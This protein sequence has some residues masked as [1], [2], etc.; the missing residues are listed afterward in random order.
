MFNLDLE[1]KKFQISSGPL[2]TV[3][4][5]FKCG[6]RAAISVFT[7]GYTSQKTDQLFWAQR[8]AKKGIDTILF[9]LPGH[10]LGE[11]SPVENFEDFTKYCPQLFSEALNL[12]S[13]QAHEKVILG[14]HSLGALLSLK[15]LEL[16][17]LSPFKKLTIAVGM[18]LELSDSP[19][20][21]EKDFFKETL[22]FRKNLVSPALAP[23][24]FFPWM[25][26]MKKNLYATNE[27]IHLIAGEDDIIV[28][29][30]GVE[31]LAKI[32]EEKNNIVTFEKPR[33]LPHFEPMLAAPYLEKI[34]STFLVS[35]S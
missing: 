11:G 1:V 35:N 29:K 24:H 15:A 5:Y 8:L 9:D 28:P 21:L 18:G 13:I 7:H 31:N 23:A 26:A 12:A 4:L 2:K 22:A 17:E 16:D 32:L 25:K 6:Q 14:G 34:I 30:N 10:L 27:R 20:P 33:R 19:H 3:A